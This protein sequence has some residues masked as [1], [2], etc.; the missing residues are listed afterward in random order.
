MRHPHGQNAMQEHTL[1]HTQRQQHS[2]GH[3]FSAQQHRTSAQPYYAPQQGSHQGGAPHDQQGLQQAWQ[4]MPAAANAAP[5]A[6]HMRASNP[7]HAQTNPYQAVPYYAQQPGATAALQNPYAPAIDVHQAPQAGMAVPG[8]PQHNPYVAQQRNPYEF[9][10]HTPYAPSNDGQ[11]SGAALAAKYEAQRQQHAS[12]LQRQQEQVLQQGLQARAHQ[13]FQLQQQE[14]RYQ[15]QLLVLEQHKRARHVQQQQ[16]QHQQR[17]QLLL[18]QEQQYHAQPIVLKQHKRAPHV[19]QQEQQQHEQPQPRHK[20]IV[21]FADDADDAEDEEAPQQ[22]AKRQRVDPETASTTAQGN[23]G[24]IAPTGSASLAD[25]TPATAADASRLAAAAAVRAAAAV[26]STPAA[27]ALGPGTQQFYAALSAEV[28][29]FAA[30]VTPTAAE[31][32]RRRAKFKVLEQVVRACLPTRNGA[33]RAQLFGSEA[34]GMATHE[35]DLDV[36]VTG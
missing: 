8:P 34:A 2:H 17:Q 11:Q 16:Q 35:S 1:Y 20:P 10:R 30:A 32:E 22:P 9:Q 33:V 13:Q 12:Q 3:Q 7:N 27:A 26:P 19:H 23:R 28:A 4:R 24:N 14:Q 36:V 21:Y 29:A 31:V 5:M 6:G 18:Q 25:T 15:A